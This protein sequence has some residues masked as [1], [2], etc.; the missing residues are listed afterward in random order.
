MSKNEKLA[1]AIRNSPKTVRFDD[2]CRMAKLL[3]FRHSHTKGSH[4]MYAR[5]GESLMLNFQNRDG[6]IYP[7]QVSQLIE[8]MDKYE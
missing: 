4:K 8:M 3:G 1:L 2:A 7:Y 5:L 6:Y